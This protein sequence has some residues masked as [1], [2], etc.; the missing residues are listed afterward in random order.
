MA[1]ALAHETAPTPLSIAHAVA[2]VMPVHDR[3]VVLPVTIVPGLAPNVPIVGFDA[4]TV[5]P[6]VAVV[7][8]VTV[9]VY[10]PA[11]AYVAANVGLS[12]PVA[13]LP[14]GADHEKLPN[15]LTAEKLAFAPRPTVCVLGLHVT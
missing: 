10:V 1:L 7:P 13:G 4:C 2:L 14:L 3:V 9:T 5:T 15:P 8:R 6:H 12:V 11:A